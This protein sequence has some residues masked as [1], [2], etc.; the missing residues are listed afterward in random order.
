MVEQRPLKA[1]VVSSNLTEDAK[2]INLKLRKMNKKEIAVHEKHCSKDTCKYGDKDC[3]IAV[4][5]SEPKE[6]I[7]KV[8]VC[9]TSTAFRT[10]EV[11]ATTEEQAID[12][13]VDEA[14]GEEFGS[15]E[16]DYT[17]DSAH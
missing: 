10:I 3:P 1:E 6:R 14:G 12:K 8:E 4:S 15:G 7:W 5:P 11:I 2:I 13:A 9:R 17:A 16:A